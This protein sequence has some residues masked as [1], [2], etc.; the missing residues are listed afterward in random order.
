MSLDADLQYSDSGSSGLE[1]VETNDAAETMVQLSV[2]PGKSICKTN[3][4]LIYT[5]DEYVIKTCVLFH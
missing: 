5:F 4:H 3:G 1:E 2:R